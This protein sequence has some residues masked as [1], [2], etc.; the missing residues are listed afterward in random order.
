MRELFNHKSS[1]GGLL[2][3]ECNPIFEASP[4]SVHKKEGTL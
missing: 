1:V 4:V 2:S 3:G